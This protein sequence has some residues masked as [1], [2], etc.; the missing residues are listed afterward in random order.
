MPYTVTQQKRGGFAY[1]NVAATE[2]AALCLAQMM[3]RAGDE[4]SAEASVTVRDGS[5][6]VIAAWR[7]SSYGWQPIEMRPA[8]PAL[9]PLAQHAA[10]GTSRSAKSSGRFGRLPTESMQSQVSGSH[11]SYA[12][13][14]VT[15]YSAVSVA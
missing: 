6:G 14:S 12:S 11:R 15:D 4:Y 1:T 5:G 13:I 8:V 2:N 3:R 9:Q 10:V 7:G